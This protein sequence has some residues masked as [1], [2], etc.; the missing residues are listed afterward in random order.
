MKLCL[1]GDRLLQIKNNTDLV[2]DIKID[3]IGVIYC[4]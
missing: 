3:H 1:T 2:F 4:G